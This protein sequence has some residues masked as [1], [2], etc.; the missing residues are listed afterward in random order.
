MRGLILSVLSCAALSALAT[1]WI[2][3]GRPLPT[4]SKS[5]YAQEPA[6]LFRARFVLPAAHRGD[7]SATVA[8]AG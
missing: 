8:C 5:L 6:P 7:L 1:V 4:D 2:G 3:D